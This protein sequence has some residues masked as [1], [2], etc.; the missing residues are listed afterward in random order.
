[1]HRWTPV[2]AALW[3]GC[4]N[5]NQLDRH[6][7]ESVAATTGDFD[8][9]EEPL[10]RMLV[11]HQTYEGLI[12]VA[13]WDPDYD[14]D[15]V[16]LKVEGLLG[17]TDEM[18]LHDSILVASGTRGLGAQEY[19]GLGADDGLVSDPAVLENVRDFVGRGGVLLCTDW[20]YDLV[21]AAWPDALGFLGDDAVYDDAQHGEIG[22]VSATVT[23]EIL[24][25]DLGMGVMSVS[26]DFSNWAVIEEVGADVTVWLVGDVEV[27]GDAGPEP[28]TRVPLLV[29]FEPEGPEAGSVVFLSFHI[30][31]QTDAVIDQLLTTVVGDFQEESDATAAIE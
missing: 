2:A 31:A 26:F 22:T 7:I 17:S 27:R 4:T 24:V 5:E 1:M 15:V 30:D 6:T 25:S 8:N 29:S 3:A 12:S 18:R 11:S 14:P 9:V 10:N 23:E 21:E 28:R 20:S 16:S 19:N 13:T